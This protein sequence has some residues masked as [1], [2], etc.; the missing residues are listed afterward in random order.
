[1]KGRAQFHSDASTLDPRIAQV[2]RSVEAALSDSTLTVQ[3]L[4]IEVRLS[5]SSL[6]RLMQLHVG[7]SPKQ[8]IVSRRLLLALDL[9]GTSFL[10]VKEIMVA[11]GIKDARHFS[12]EFRRMFGESPTES[13]A[14]HL[15]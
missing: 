13:R 12:R 4:A 15:K 2:I 8:Y 3:R 14:A 9:L 11:V 10:S 7:Q 1:M 6:R 5:S